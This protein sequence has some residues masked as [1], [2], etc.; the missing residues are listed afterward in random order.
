[1]EAVFA[2]IDLS[3]AAA[4]ISGVLVLG[5]GIAMAFKAAGLGKKAV[6]HA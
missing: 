1:M 3:G 2:A 4:A 5:I 6:S